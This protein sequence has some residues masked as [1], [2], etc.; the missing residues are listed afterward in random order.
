VIANNKITIEPLFG[1]SLN[2]R[3][4]EVTIEFLN[5]AHLG[6]DIGAMYDFVRQFGMDVDKILLDKLL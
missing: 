5:A 1:Q 3:T 6:F 4:D 2:E